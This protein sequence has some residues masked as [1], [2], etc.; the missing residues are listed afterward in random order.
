M[1]LAAWLGFGTLVEWAERVRLFRGPLSESLRRTI[2]LP[3][4]AYGMTLAHLGLAIVIV[5]ITG[6]SAWKVESVQNQKPGETV[7]VSGYDFTLMGVRQHEGPNYSAQAGTFA[8]F[9]GSQSIGTM[10]A[11][12]RQYTQPPRPTTEAAIQ[13]YWHGDLYAVIGDADGKGGYVTRLYYNPLIPWLWAGTLLM[14]VGGLV[15]LTDRRHRVGAPTR[16]TVAPA[17][18]TQAAE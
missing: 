17:G 13:T 8:V 3:R 10:E 5:G 6:A 14:V 9:K 18:A 1:A 16:R 7:R 12:K 4:S 15:S 2:R 11:E